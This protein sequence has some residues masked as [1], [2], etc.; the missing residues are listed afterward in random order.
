M[1]IGVSTSRR[2][3][4]SQSIVKV[5][6]LDHNRVLA[7]I[8]PHF[9]TTNQINDAERVVVWSD[10]TWNERMIVEAAQRKGIPTITVQHGR[11][12]TSRYYPPFNERIKSDVLLVWGEADRE[13]LVS[14]GQDTNKIKVTGTTLFSHLKGR[15]PHKKK[16][17]VFSPDHWDKELEENLNV[18][19]E[20]NKLRGVKTI[21][22][23]VDGNEPSLYK[24]P[25]V[26]HRDSP[27]HMEIV[28]NTLADADIVVSVADGTFE[29]LAMSLDI[30][31][32]TVT[33]WEPKAFGGDQRYAQGYRRIVS[34]GTTPT[35][36]GNLKDT[37]IRELE[38]PARLW[39]Q[40]LTTIER[41]GGF[42]LNAKQNI[43]NAITEATR[44]S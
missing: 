39:R 29:M 10:V 30:P 17:V 42:R 21:T 35:N 33:D 13:A 23:L 24:N 25:V 31:V 37:V 44:L 18:A 26:S 34:D 43:I 8:M 40:R 6:F 12:G 16:V 36:L 20:L 15:I 2:D 3:E 5:L 28:A 7:D 22:K 14:A 41:D 11:R 4:G 27:E 19:K 9:E 38:N 32:V 1:G